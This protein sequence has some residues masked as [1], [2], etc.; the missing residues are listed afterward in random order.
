MPKWIKDMADALKEAKAAEKEA[1]DAMEKAKG[2]APEKELQKAIV[3]IK[4]GQENL[5]LVDAGGGAH[6]KSLRL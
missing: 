1:I 4:K 6:N 2:K 3:L 5:R